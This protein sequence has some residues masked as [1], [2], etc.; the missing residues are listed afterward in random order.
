MEIAYKIWVEMIT[1]KVALI[2]D[3]ENDVIVE[4]YNSWYDCF[5]NIRENIKSITGPNIECSKDLIDFLV[6]ILNGSLREHL[7]K[8]QA[9]FR[10]WYDEERTNCS[11][12]MSPQAI[13]KQYPEY[14]ELIV[15]LKQTNKELIELEKQLHVFLFE[16]GMIS[17]DS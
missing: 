11:N 1:R 14:K 12:E 4:V 3:E 6:K 16:S 15:D 2:F 8:W 10:K 17:K 7:T 9:K 13:Q 5:K